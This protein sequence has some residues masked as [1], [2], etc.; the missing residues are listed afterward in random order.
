MGSLSILFWS[1]L[2]KEFI[3]KT[4]S[5]NQSKKDHGHMLVEQV[6]EPLSKSKHTFAFKRDALPGVSTFPIISFSE[7]KHL[8]WNK[9]LPVQSKPLY[10]VDPIGQAD[11]CADVFQMWQ[12]EDCSVPQQIRF[13]PQGYLSVLAI[14]NPVVNFSELLCSLFGSI[15]KGLLFQRKEAPEGFLNLTWILFL[16][17]WQ[18][19]VMV[20]PASN[21]WRLVRLYESDCEQNL[22]PGLK[23]CS[24]SSN[25]WWNSSFS[26][27]EPGISRRP[28]P[29][30]GSSLQRHCKHP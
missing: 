6:Q 25:D 20:K 1:N 24:L 18:L 9:Q 23:C 11:R 8:S 16:Y 15:C 10:L 12:L 30:S 5:I 3:Y 27:F 13:T 17:S 4:K 29:P 14:N 22:I 26:H 21:Q 19:W 28:W 7:H 2:Y